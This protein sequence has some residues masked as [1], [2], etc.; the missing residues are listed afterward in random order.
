MINPVAAGN[1]LVCSCTFEPAV[2]ITLHVI[3]KKH[4]FR[5]SSNSEALVSELKKK[6]SSLILLFSRS[7]LQQLTVN[8]QIAIETIKDGPLYIC[9]CLHMLL[10]GRVGKWFDT[11][12]DPSTK[13]DLLLSLFRLTSLGRIAQLPW[14]ETS[15]FEPL[16]NGF[17]ICVQFQI[18]YVRFST[19]K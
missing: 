4:S 15:F 13:I 1:T 8:L 16:R 3:S 17:I 11:Q 14:S 12:V 6:V 18:K 7:L 9:N 5:Y 10:N 2:D 19:I